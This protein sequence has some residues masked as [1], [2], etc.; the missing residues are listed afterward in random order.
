MYNKYDK[1]KMKFN[2][3]HFRER[4]ARGSIFGND[5]KYFYIWVVI[6]FS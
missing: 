4:H 5:Q 6:S 2:C 3:T 1:N